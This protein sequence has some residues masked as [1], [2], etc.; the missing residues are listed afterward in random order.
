MK[1]TTTNRI[2]RT[3][4]VLTAF[5][6]TFIPVKANDSAYFTSGNQLIPLGETNIS[7]KKEILSITIGDDSY[8]DVDVY[9]EF[10][11]P[12][13]TRTILMGFEADPP[14]GAVS[15]EPTKT[16][17]HPFIHGFTVS[18]NGTPLSYSNAITQPMKDG[19]IH[20]INMQ[21]WN[22]FEEGAVVI[23]KKDSDQYQNYSFV[24]YFNATFKPG[25]NII[26][27]TYRYEMSASVVNSYNISY[28]LSPALRWSNHQIDDF[29]LRLIAGSKEKDFIVCGKTFSPEKT[30]VTYGKGKSRN[31]TYKDYIQ[32]DSLSD[33]NEA[34]LPCIEVALRGGSIEWHFANFK[35]DEELQIYSADR[36]YS[37]DNDYNPYNGKNIGRYYDPAYGPFF[38]QKDYNSKERRIIRNL[39][40][41]SRGYVFKN[42]KLKAYFSKLWWYMPNS[43]WQPSTND[44]NKEER[45]MIKK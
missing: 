45:N 38:E 14:Y 40:Y 3:V 33:Y 43:S 13:S 44:F 16:L 21:E 20:P 30:K 5:L 2:F 27:H 35:P 15:F 11:N 17:E 25:I 22:F 6:L 7:V 39:P 23:N 12:D 26:H 41:A 32:A 31:D 37:L 34:T 9:Y 36:K 18:I 8:A 28:K 19:K 10:Y 1:E 29:T 24:Y 4:M 42:K